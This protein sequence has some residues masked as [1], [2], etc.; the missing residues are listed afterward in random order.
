MSDETHKSGTV[1]H[2][3]A[4]LAHADASPF[5]TQTEDTILSAKRKIVSKT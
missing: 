4:A 1:V 5:T 2:R 3:S